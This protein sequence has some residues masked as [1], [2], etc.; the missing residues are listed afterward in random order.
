MIL[1]SLNWLS[2]FKSGFLGDFIQEDKVVIEYLNWIYK[3]T[4]GI[5]QKRVY[6]RSQIVT[7]S[8]ASSSKTIG[9]T[10]DHFKFP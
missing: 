4:N 8:E 6:F 7:S 3:N 5:I 10:S 9:L 2:N 1:S